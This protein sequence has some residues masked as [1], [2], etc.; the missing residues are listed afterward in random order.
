MRIAFYAPLKPPDHP[1]PSG[2]R[3][4][5]QMIV[6]ALG[7]AGH[8]VELAARFRSYEGTGDG[9]R[10]M[11][12][13]QIGGRLAA[14]LI[15]RL[16]GR[17]LSQRPCIWVTYHLY[18][19]APDWIGPRV[20]AQLAIPYVVIEASHAAKRAGGPWS[21][22]HEAT[23]AALARALAVVSLN[24]AD[25]DGVLTAL[26]DPAR[27]HRLKPFLNA[28]PFARAARERAANRLAVGRRYGLESDRPWLLA[29]GMMRPGDKLASYILLGEAL[30]TLADRPWRLLVVGDGRA[31]PEVEAAL[32]PLGE[33]VHYAGGIEPAAMPAIY[34]ACDLLVWPAIN[35]AYG[36]ALL[37]A[38]AA[39]LLVV[40]G[41][42]GGGPNIVADGRT[43]LFAPPRDAAA[44][45][46]LVG[47]LLADPARRRAMAEA[48]L[49]KVAAEHDLPV[50]GRALDAV[51]TAA[52]QG[53]P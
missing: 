41:R 32:A 43:G 29:V 5:A 33:R 27:L 35:E 4:M 8:E 22:G 53:R 2:D 51:I 45:A 46:A 36:M 30:A 39:G 3:R 38:Q 6:A 49:A 40:A 12:L 25:D 7:L 47:E 11:R 19:K 52:Q 16:R 10:Q 44:F 15:G 21:L 20:A 13:A 50:A 48:S 9:E 24:P 34:A 18:Y 28:T 23:L 31:R 26:S 17:P 14:R 42:S 37:E 1:V